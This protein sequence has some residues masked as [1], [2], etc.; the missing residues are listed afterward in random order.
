MNTLKTIVIFASILLMFSASSC[1]KEKTLIIKETVII[2]DGNHN[3]TCGDTTVAPQS[4]WQYHATTP[5][6]DQC[7]NLLWAVSFS[8]SNTL[9]K[10]WAPCTGTPTKLDDKYYF[11]N[12]IGN[13]SANGAMEANEYYYSSGKNYLVYEIHWEWNEGANNS[14]LIPHPEI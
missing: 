13:L 6:L 14:Y 5:Y 8:G 9:Y 4:L 10:V 7:T 12:T 1:K 2:H 11:G 3:D